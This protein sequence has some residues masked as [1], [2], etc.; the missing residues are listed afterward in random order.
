[1][2][3]ATFLIFF[4]FLFVIWL[5]R[6][7]AAVFK[8]LPVLLF[9]TCVLLLP[10]MQQAAAQPAN[11]AWIAEF[12]GNFD[13]GRTF[14]DAAAGAAIRRL[15]VQ[16]TQASQ[17]Y[18]IEWDSFSNKWQNTSTPVN[19][20]FTLFHGGNGSPNGQLSASATADDYYTFQIDGLAY[21]NRQ[22]VVM[23]TS[24]PP[25]GFDGSAPVSFNSSVEP[26]EEL[27]ITITLSGP[28]SPEER[29]FVRYTT[30]NFSSSELA[31][32]SFASGTASSG[33]ATIPG[34]AN[35]DG[36]EVRF[37]VYTTTVAAGSDSNH[38]LISLEIANNG[39]ANYSYTPAFSPPDAITL[40]SPAD[41]AAN[42]APET[43]LS[44]ESAANVAEYELQ[45]SSTSSFAEADIISEFT[46]ADTSMDVSLRMGETYFWR[47]RGQNSGGDGPY[48]TTFSFSTLAP[49]VT[50]SG[51]GNSDFGGIIGN[52]TLEIGDDG[53][54]LYFSFVR[55]DGE[56]AGFNDELVLYFSTG[57]DGR[58]RIDSEVNDEASLQRR[59]VSSAGAN[60][61][62]LQF[63][64]GFEATHAAVL[65]PDG[66]A[67]FEIPADGAISNNDL[68][69]VSGLS[70]AS[71]NED[72]DFSFSYDDLGLGENASFDIVGIYLNGS[73]GFTSNE[74]YGLGF[75]ET[76]IGGQNFDFG[77]FISYPSGRETSAY[78]SVADGNWSAA[79]TWNQGEVPPAGSAV[80]ITS[81]VTLDTNA[82]HGRVEIQPGG[83]LSFDAAAGRSLTLSGGGRFINDGSFDAGSSGRVI[84]AGEE[85]SRVAGSS[86]T[87]FARLLVPAG[88]SARSIRF[89]TSASIRNALFEGAAALEIGDGSS[90]SFET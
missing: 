26:G 48:S 27:D 51:N 15:T 11:Y 58:S 16:A 53:S 52:S 55:A 42:L 63:L 19:E 12:D 78:I 32:V 21:S 90:L 46:T 10:G 22:A 61:S 39:G 31:E 79:G 83:A 36:D 60:A 23:Q 2:L 29:A 77:S 38:D 40:S 62:E 84:F 41:G 50:L 13:N 49:E 72:F 35:Q 74:G 6:V 34:S 56:T 86:E 14:N 87:S 73:N 69:E 71:I 43:T 65:S 75:P 70:T 59:A 45:L 37:Y 28:K 7:R 20:V 54:Q 25:V 76:N 44:W 88:G 8:G 33:T 5:P 82:T 3:M 89:E 85:T 57:A 9:A 81:A 18:V 17:D 1:M 24:A 64:E 80:V 47:V 66:S 67:L 4:R 68:N 30:D